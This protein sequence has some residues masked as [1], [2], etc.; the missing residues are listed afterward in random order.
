MFAQVETTQTEDPSLWDKIAEFKEQAAEFT[1]VFTRM[2]ELREV[3]YA[4]PTA[5]SNYDALMSA[6]NSVMDKIEAV[7]GTIDRAVGAVTN[8]FGIEKE[9]LGQFAAVPLVVIAVIAGGTALIVGWLAKA[10]IQLKELECAESLIQEGMTAAEAYKV[11]RSQQTG[12]VG[13]LGNVLMMAL[14]VGGAVFVLTRKRQ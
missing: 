10:Y 14:L 13:T 2:R 9:Q 4:D 7:T 5:R 6:A 8:L 1:R 12:I 11:C 3:A